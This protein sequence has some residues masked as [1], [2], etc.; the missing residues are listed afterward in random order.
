VVA[1]GGG[2]PPGSVNLVNWPAAP[3]GEANGC[4]A[5]PPSDLFW[6]LSP[7][8][9]GQALAQGVT[10]PSAGHPSDGLMNHRPKLLLLSI[11][12]ASNEPIQDRPLVNLNLRF[13]FSRNMPL[14]REVAAANRELPI[15]FITGYGDIPM[16]VQAMKGGAIEFLTKPFRDQDLLDAIQFGLSR[17]RVQENDKTLAILRERFTSLS[18]RERDIMIRVARGRLS[19]QIAGAAPA[20]HHGLIVE[21]ERGDRLQGGSH[22]R[23]PFSPPAV[24]GE[25]VGMMSATVPTAK[26][27]IYAASQL[28]SRV[29]EYFTVLRLAGELI[30]LRS[31]HSRSVLGLNDLLIE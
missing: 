8:F 28:C 7:G 19:K 3:A 1:H 11:D 25:P 4:T 10:A 29:G 2:L 26:G 15:I 31:L 24:A 21:L 14:Q 18:P 17:D 30:R 20:Q 12:K 5:G 23:N 9:G 6:N 22:A 16:T 13:A 27:G